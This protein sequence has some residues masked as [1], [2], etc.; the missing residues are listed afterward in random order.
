[1]VLSLI[2]AATAFSALVLGGIWLVRRPHAEAEGRLRALSF[3]NQPA[4]AGASMGLGALPSRREKRKSLFSSRLTGKTEARLAKAGSSLT[5]AAF[6][7]IVLLSM[8][9]CLFAGYMILSMGLEASSGVVIAGVVV[10]GVLGAYL[11]FLWLRSASSA[12]TRELRVQLPDVLDLLTLCVESGLGL[13]AAFR[14]VTEE[15]SGPLPDEISIMLHEVDLGK[16]RREALEDMAGRVQIPEVDVV[17]NSMIQSQQMGTSLSAT[18][19]SQTHLLR[20]RRRQKAEQSA[21]QASVKM[22]FPLVLFLMPSLFIVIL[23]PIAINIFKV[24]N[25]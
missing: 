8:F 1:M 22:A 15:T 14:R 11:P 6:Y 5:P 9:A 20:M 7:M 25:D 24:L 4:T 12:R 16:P 17:V 10:P 13:D 19:R 2:A 21:R 23:G 18:L 3:A